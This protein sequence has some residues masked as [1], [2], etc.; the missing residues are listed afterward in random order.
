MS[1]MT[2]P[3][4]N[5][6]SFEREL[7]RVR[8]AAAGPTLI[9][10]AGIHGNEHG[11]AI[12][13]QRVFERFAKDRTTLRGEVVAFAG[14]LASLRLRR[15]F[16]SKDLNRQWTEAKV[17]SLLARDASVD[18]AED[19]EQRALIACVD[20]ALSRAR[21]PV[22]FVD[23]H[24]TSAAG[25]P[26]ALY[27]D[28][29]AQA[30]FASRFPL[31]IILGLEEEVDGVLS[32][33]MSRRGCVSLAVEG[34]Q[35]D[36]PRTID[37]LEAVLWVALA[38]AGLAERSALPRFAHSRAHLHRARGE[39]PRVL[40]VLR[41]H[42]IT[43]EHRFVMEP[44]FS[45][46]A[47]VRDGQLLAREHGGEVRAPSDG[48]VMLPLY[49]GQGDDGFFWGREVSRARLRASALL[50]RLGVDRVLPLLPGVRRD[51][52]VPHRLVLSESAQKR[53]PLGLFRTLGMRR[54]REKNGARLVSK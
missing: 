29:I 28:T 21:G 22:Y 35:H 12:A 20:A 4:R 43:P 5:A 19:R 13:A 31:P 15:R 48:Y 3:E 17:A 45:N 51:S 11:G 50:Q 32:S 2:E 6:M 52:V 16:A 40:E 47:K 39:M 27:G 46:L 34:G 23:L 44:G 24:T 25:F 41:R 26:F 37:H 10:V 9:V 30:L 14:N 33:Y 18:D 1:T 54:V 36:D 49:Q 53:Y 38:A 7:G 42:A 8:G